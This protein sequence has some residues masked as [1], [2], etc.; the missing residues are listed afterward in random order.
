MYYFV[1]LC[2][3]NVCNLTLYGKVSNKGKHIYSYRNARI[4]GLP[5][6]KLLAWCSRAT[7]H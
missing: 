7:N 5:V 1:L 4:C 2:V 6:F 3:V